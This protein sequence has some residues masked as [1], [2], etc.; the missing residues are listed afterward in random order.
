MTNMRFEFE[1]AH[2]RNAADPDRAKRELW[3]LPTGEYSSGYVA[4]RWRLWTEAWLAAWRFANAQS[5]PQPDAQ[6][7]EPSD[8][9]ADLESCVVEA[10]AD[11][12]SAVHECSGKVER[13]SHKEDLSDWSL[14]DIKASVRAMTD[15]PIDQITIVW[16]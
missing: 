14:Q 4:D 16:S 11:G 15:C 3:K 6:A 12:W 10:N 8:E 1:K 5:D 13:L 9:T 2:I 7:E